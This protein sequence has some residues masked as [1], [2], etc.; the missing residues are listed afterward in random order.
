MPL[1]G[2]FVPRHGDLRILLGGNRQESGGRVGLVAR[3]RRSVDTHQRA[4]F[5]DDG[6]KDLSGR[7]AP[8]DKCGDA[9]KR[10]L[11]GLDL[12]EV[13]LRRCALR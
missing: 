6:V 11:L 9:P 2:Q 4:D 7:H 3:K 12:R 5:V 8:G 1:G 10:G 13:L